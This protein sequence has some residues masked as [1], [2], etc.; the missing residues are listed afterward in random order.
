MSIPSNGP[1]NLC[2]VHLNGED[3]IVTGNLNPITVVRTPVGA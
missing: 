1:T 3:Q 2:V